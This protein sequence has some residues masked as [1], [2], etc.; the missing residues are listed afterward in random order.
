V[1]RASE[2][3]LPKVDAEN[4]EEIQG[5]VDGLAAEGVKT[6][7]AEMVAYNAWFETG[8]WWA[9]E[10]ERL[11]SAGEPSS[12]QSCSAFIATGSITRDH[13]IVLAHNTWFGYGEAD[14]NVIL[15]VVP[16][17][18][19]RILM[20]TFPGYV[21]SA[22]D[23]FVTSAGLVGAETTIGDFT[24][25]EENATPEFARMRRATQDARSID[26][27]VGIMKAG[28]N[29][30]YANAWLLGDTKTNTIARLELGLKHVAFEK[31]TDGVYSGSNIAEDVQ[32]LRFET[33]SNDTDIRKPSIAR[34][35][36]WHELLKRDAGTIDVA[37][38]EAFLGDDYD[39]LLGRR[40]PTSR[41]LCGRADLDPGTSGLGQ[42]FSPS[43][44]FD[45]KVVDAAMAG[46]MRI[47]AHWGA[48]CGSPFDA[49]AFLAAHG[50]FEWMA[51]LLKSR[52]EEPWV[53][54]RAGEK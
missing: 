38:A 21:H 33:T 7:L 44:A 11:G 15:D 42:P 54:F 43:G 13:K 16:E 48:A 32:I 3:F 50:Q 27:W 30:G 8:D 52:P 28:N 19:S 34:R 17:K 39:T 49:P 35:V 2:V 51:G 25:F 12:R 14:A 23:F 20:Q 53:E 29:G 36:R 5:I 31:T 26:E 24:S 45:G 9:K 1:K 4:R 22:T 37:R 41:S 6:S 47:A 10:K 40:G 46:E 18:G